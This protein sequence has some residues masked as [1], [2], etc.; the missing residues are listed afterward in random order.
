VTDNV[1]A[2]LTA[3]ELAVIAQRAL[4]LCADF[5]GLMTLVDGEQTAEFYDLNRRARRA[6]WELSTD[7]SQHVDSVDNYRADVEQRAK[8]RHPATKR[9]S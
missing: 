7:V 3:A 6:F 5:Y 9:E 8:Q 1:R 4:N 2:S